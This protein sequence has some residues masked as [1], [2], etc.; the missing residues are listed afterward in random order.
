MPYFIPLRCCFVGWFIYLVDLGDPHVLVLWLFSRLNQKKALGCWQKSWTKAGRKGFQHG[1]WHRKQQTVFQ[2][3]L[4][5]Q[6]VRLGHC[7]VS[8]VLPSCS[9]ALLERYFYFTTEQLEKNRLVQP[10]H[11]RRGSFVHHIAMCLFGRSLAVNCV[12]LQLCVY[13]AID[14]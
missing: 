3:C 4:G 7:T 2:L 9:S 11:V 6:L 1:F 12:V 10:F 8:S 14:L 5:S 13:S